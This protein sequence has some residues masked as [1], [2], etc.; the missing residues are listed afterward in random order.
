[1]ADKPPSDDHW[2]VRPDTIRK[3]WRYGFGFLLFLMVLDV[4]LTKTHLIHHHDHF[5][6]EAIPTFSAFY[7]LIAC[8]V[9]VVG[10]KLL[11]VLLKRPDTYYDD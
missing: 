6:L 10:S 9:L 11:G 1:M 8:I 2:L 3:M 5:G 7:G 4:V